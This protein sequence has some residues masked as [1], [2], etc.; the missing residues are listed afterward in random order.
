[1]RL[2]YVFAYHNI[3]WYCEFCHIRMCCHVV[4]YLLSK[5]LSRACQWCHNIIVIIMIGRMYFQ[6][7][8]R[9]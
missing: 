3:V 1:M 6:N 8:C 9:S 5:L 7:N 4:Q 2:L